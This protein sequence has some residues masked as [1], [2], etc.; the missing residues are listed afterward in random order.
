MFAKFECVSTNDSTT[1]LFVMHRKKKSET[2]PLKAKQT[3][4]TDIGRDTRTI[5]KGIQL[6]H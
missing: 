4:Q 2:R 5:V 1:E 3:K 6:F